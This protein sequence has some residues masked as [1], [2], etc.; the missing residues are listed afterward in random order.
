VR[1]DDAQARALG[2]RG[3][4]LDVGLPLAVSWLRSFEP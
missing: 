2:V 1:V 4:G 3:R